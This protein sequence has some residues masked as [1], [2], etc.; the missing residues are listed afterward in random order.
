MPLS[1]GILYQESGIR[2]QKSGIRNQVYVL[3]VTIRNDYILHF[4]SHNTAQS[5][6]GMMNRM[7]T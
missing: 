3:L 2:N 7:D 1:V 4:D 6:V 5:V